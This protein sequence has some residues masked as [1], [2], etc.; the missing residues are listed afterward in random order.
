MRR[1]MLTKPGAYG[2]AVA[3]VALC[4]RVRWLLN[5]L[6]ENQGLYLAFMIPVASS[7]YVGGPGPG[8]VSAVLS[9]AIANP[10]LVQFRV[11]DGRASTAHL[12]LFGIECAAVILLIRKLQESRDAAG[13]A[14]AVAET[15]RNL[16]EEAN[17]ASETRRGHAR[18]GVNSQNDGFVQASLR[19]D[20]QFAT[21]RHS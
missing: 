21:D 11:P 4:T 17:R 16:A 3:S 19:H 12:V 15:A 18:A 14:L 1:T 20:W 5:P 2:F 9:A 13:Q 7:A 8:L 6:L 10:L